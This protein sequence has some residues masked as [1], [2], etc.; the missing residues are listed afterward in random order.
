[1]YHVYSLR[2]RQIEDPIQWKM[3]VASRVEGVIRAFLPAL[4]QGRYE[5]RKA[6]MVLLVEGVILSLHASNWVRHK[7]H[8]E[9]KHLFRRATEILLYQARFYSGRARTCIREIAVV[10]CRPE[11]A[12]KDR[13][14]G[15]RV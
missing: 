15:C 10:F 12:V 11:Q 13:T 1:M 14:S 5:T 2:A 9:Q 8:L 7:T 3:F 4:G 6:A